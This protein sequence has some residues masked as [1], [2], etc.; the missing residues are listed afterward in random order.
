MLANM[1]AKD[2]VDDRLR[3]VEARA[4]LLAREAGRRALEGFRRPLH[5]EYKRQNRAD[6][7]TDADR[8]IE[9]FLRA[10]IAREFP[11]HAILGE[12]GTEVEAGEAEFLWV[13]DPVDGTTNFVNGFPIFACSLGLLRYG[14]P[15]VGAIFLPVTP[16]VATSEG[17]EEVGD[18]AAGRD[19]GS[20]VLHARLGGG[21]FLDGVPVRASTAPAPEPSSLAG[22]PGH[23]YR[24]FSRLRGLQRNAGELRC[25]G[26]VCYE[27]AMVACGVF[28]YTA[29]RSPRVWD[30]AAG[31]LIVR[32]AGGLSLAWRRGEWEPLT[33]FEPM[34]NPAKPGER[35]LRFWTAITLFG[36][37]R[38]ARHVAERL[39]PRTSLRERLH[40]KRDGTE[41]G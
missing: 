10:A 27:M 9:G 5:V 3:E 24:Q 7:V 33:R 19:L 22:L 40:E 2:R 38:V 30:L 21:A 39:R 1:N 20:G 6:P 36:G 4:V 37:S 28:R 16:R 23:H 18:E 29:F 8:G 32:E 41:R 13:L 14:E 26:S 17:M 25:L 34:S 31:T 15:V 12:E 35:G 11:Q